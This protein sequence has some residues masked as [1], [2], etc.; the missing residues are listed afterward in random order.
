MQQ[1][2]HQLSA[3]RS[4]QQVVENLTSNEEAVGQDTTAASELTTDHTGAR[5]APEVTTAGVQ[6]HTH[7]LSAERSSQQVVEK[8]TS[9]GETV[10]QDTTGN[11][12]LTT[13]HTGS[14]GDLEVTATGIQHTHQESVR[15]MPVVDKTDHRRETVTTPDGQQRITKESEFVVQIAS[16]SAWPE[17]GITSTD[18]EQGILNQ[19][20]RTTRTESV[21]EEWEPAL[22][23]A[24]GLLEPLDCQVHVNDMSKF[25]ASL[26]CGY[27]HASAAVRG[28]LCVM[29]AG[30]S[31]CAVPIVGLCHHCWGEGTPLL[32]DYD[33]ATVDCWQFY[34]TCH[35]LKR[36]RQFKLGVS[37]VCTRAG[38]A[39]GSQADTEEFK[40][41]ARDMAGSSGA[42]TGAGAG[43]GS[44]TSFKSG[45]KSNT[46]RP[47]NT[48]RH[49]TATAAAAE[50]ADR[51]EYRVSQLE[52]CVKRNAVNILRLHN[53]HVH[54]KPRMHMWSWMNFEEQH[55][56]D[57]DEYR[58]LLRFRVSQFEECV[59]RN[60]V[61]ILRLHNLHVH[62]KPR[63]W[64]WCDRNDMVRLGAHRGKYLVRYLVNVNSDN[65]MRS[66]LYQWRGRTVAHSE[67]DGRIRGRVIS[68]NSVLAENVTPDVLREEWWKTFLYNTEYK[69]S[70]Y[71]IA[72]TLPHKLRIW[73]RQSDDN[74]RLTMDKKLERSEGREEDPIPLVFQSRKG[75][76]DEGHTYMYRLST[77]ARR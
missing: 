37:E 26:S 8:L 22:S 28:G 76:R 16:S 32:W 65:I 17:A 60:A 33:L 56:A 14:R 34:S 74:Y 11:P 31:V 58:G 73:N 23:V 46:T 62:V 64:T 4:S 25:W 20:N 15:L 66:L 38:V 27:A 68:C 72:N 3:E 40:R 9:K 6:Q 19:Y 63:V 48:K 10:D 35:C 13:D 69:I 53:L 57:G 12:E 44:N 51:E 77:A 21:Q 1:H 43:S 5:G 39:R 67:G 54:V 61:N 24:D 42:A 47:D 52:E 2:T 18:T 45:P 70:E 41:D 36:S 29:T 30:L 59:K 49:Q 75:R 55:K 71:L 50:S 7:Q